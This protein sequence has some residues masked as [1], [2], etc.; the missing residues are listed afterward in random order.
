MFH[1]SHYNWC[2]LQVSENP[3]SHEHQGKPEPACHDQNQL[4]SAP[5]Q[6]SAL[7]RLDA[8]SLNTTHCTQVTSLSWEGLFILLSNPILSLCCKSLDN[9]HVRESHCHQQ[10]HP[11]SRQKASFCSNCPD[12]GSLTRKA[13]RPLR[14]L[15]KG[16]KKFIA[17][18]LRQGSVAR[19]SPNQ[20]QG[21]DQGQS[22][23]DCFPCQTPAQ[24]GPP[25]KNRLVQQRNKVI[26]H[27]F[28][29]SS[30]VQ[31]LQIIDP[32]KYEYCNLPLRCLF[33]FS[34]L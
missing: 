30:V 19:E 34:L 6:C 11:M 27:S 3:G 8:P 22:L 25:G 2:N 9:C 16:K 29:I 15:D 10:D 20:Y 18:M 17:L 7:T 33:Y 24:R 32:T 4:A 28:W 21:P 1:I 23:D 5:T 13:A 31:S 14:R 26:V 12:R